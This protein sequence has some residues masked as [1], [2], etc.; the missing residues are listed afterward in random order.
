MFRMVELPAKPI[1]IPTRETADFITSH[2]PT[3]ATVLEIGCGE[4]H[5]AADLKERGLRVVGIDPDPEAINSARQKGVSAMLG[6]WPATDVEP[7]DAI[8]FTRSLHHIDDLNGAIHKAAKVLP[9]G[10]VLLLEDF[11][12][13][14]TDQKTLDWFLNLIANEEI[15]FLIGQVPDEFVT[16]ML[17]ADDPFEEWKHDQHHDLHSAEAMGDAIKERFMIK[18]EASVP[19]FFRYLV[20]VFPKTQKAADLVVGVLNEELELGKKGEI[21]LVGRRI[22]AT[23]R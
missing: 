2:L 5:V 18:D 10:G 8:A 11:A 15:S 20:P 1:D 7:V 13:N 9:H 4:G 14:V 3:D 6:N 17:S 23:K 21:V 22:V 12:F 19:Y 16:R